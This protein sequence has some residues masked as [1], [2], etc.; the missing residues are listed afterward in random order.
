MMDGPLFGRYCAARDNT[1]GCD[2][3]RL[4]TPSLAHPYVIEQVRAW[5]DSVDHR[6]L[7]LDL[8]SSGPAADCKS[9]A[10]KNGIC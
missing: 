3:G 5:R 8:Q 9:S 7:P 2:A 6:S 10:S 4:A 1:I